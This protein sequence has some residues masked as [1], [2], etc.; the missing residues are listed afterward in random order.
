M[1]NHKASIY[2]RLCPQCEEY[3]KT[4]TESS[5]AVCESCKKINKLKRYGHL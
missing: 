5:K 4:T 3:H 1:G 2:T